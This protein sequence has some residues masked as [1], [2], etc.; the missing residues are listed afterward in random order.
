MAHNSMDE[1]WEIYTFEVN[2]HTFNQIDKSKFPGVNFINKGVWSE[3]G[4]R[5][6][7]L[8]TW[9]GKIDDNHNR[10]MLDKET[11][12]QQVGGASHVLE[13]RWVK[14]HYIADHYIDPETIDVECIDLVQ[15][16]TENFSPSDHIVVKFDIEGAEYTILEKM[17]STGAIDYVNSFY[18]EWHQRLM[19]DV[20]DERKIIQTIRDKGIALHPWS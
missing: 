11:A 13:D 5:K 8:E 10:F 18:I 17:I 12:N 20:Y 7:T 16:I 19:K 14:P 6:L 3:S 15:F 1:T 4:T 9:P 2:P